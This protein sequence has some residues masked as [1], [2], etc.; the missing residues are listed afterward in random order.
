MV[1]A[2]TADQQHAEAAVDQFKPFLP[3]GGDDSLGRQRPLV[4]L[5]ALSAVSA[6]AADITV[7][8]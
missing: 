1:N 4:G 5:T 2:A 6:L 8:R 7:C 3:E